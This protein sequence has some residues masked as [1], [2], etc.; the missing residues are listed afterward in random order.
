ML[1]G[2]GSNYCFKT[3]DDVDVENSSPSKSKVT[4]EVELLRLLNIS[5]ITDLDVTNY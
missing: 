3:E 4:T 5:F 2:Q 1:V